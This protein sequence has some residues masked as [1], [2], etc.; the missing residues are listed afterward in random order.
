M[1]FL[2]KE[3]YMES[4]NSKAIYIPKTTSNITVNIFDKNIITNLI[5]AQKSIV[6]VFSI[7]SE[8]TFLFSL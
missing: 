3:W 7:I 8:E 4:P 2:R 5:T 6:V 1:V